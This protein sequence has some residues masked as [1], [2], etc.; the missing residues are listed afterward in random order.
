MNKGVSILV[1]DDEKLLR[2]LLV[3]ILSKEGY[4]VETA[5]D[6][7]DALNKLRQQKYHLLISDIKMPRLNGFELAQLFQPNPDS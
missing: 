3:K 1:V 4:T 6:G 5:V 2:D 7:E